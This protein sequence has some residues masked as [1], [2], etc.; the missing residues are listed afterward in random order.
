M[1]ISSRELLQLGISVVPEGS[2]VGFENYIVNVLQSQKDGLILCSESVNS[3]NQIRNL[4]IRGNLLLV[5]RNFSG[6]SIKGLIDI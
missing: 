1:L 3:G 5:V 4:L 2:F 6:H